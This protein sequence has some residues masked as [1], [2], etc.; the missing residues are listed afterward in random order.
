MRILFC[1]LFA[2]VFVSQAQIIKLASLAPSGSPWDEGLKSIASEWKKISNNSV[3][4]K[5]YPGGIAGDEAD[6]IRKIRIGQVQAAGLTGIGLSRIHNGVLAIQLPLVVRTSEELDYVLGKMEPALEKELA[7]K[8]FK[9]LFWMPVGWVHFFGTAPI[10]APDDLRK[11]KLFTWA[12]DADG[13]QTWKESGFH[14][15]PLAVT[16]MM[17]SL[18]SGMV[19]AFS[20]TPLSA[21]SYQWFGLA[22]NMCDMKWAPLIGGMVISITAWEAFPQ[23]LR[24]TLAD[25]ARKVGESLKVESMNADDKAITIMKQYGLSVNPVSNDNLAAWDVVAQNGIAKVSGKSFDPKTFELVK[26]YLA[27]YRAAHP[28]QPGAKPQ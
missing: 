27:E 18:Q 10:S 15:I 8:G 28:A 26:K 17:S 25:A 20:A 7:D 24:G 21:A 11:L 14:P 9:V 19:N 2:A 3:T 23:D 22:K 12:G 13:V 1:V 6:V 5:I 16:D 4:V